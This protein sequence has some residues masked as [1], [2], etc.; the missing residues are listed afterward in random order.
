MSHLRKLKLISMVQVDSFKVLCSTMTALERL[1]L[2]SWLNMQLNNEGF[3]SITKLNN[4]TSLYIYGLDSLTDEG[5]GCVSRLT[6]LR[7]LEFSGEGVTTD[8]LSELQPLTN[9]K[10][11]C[12]NSSVVKQ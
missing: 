5:F 1:Y 4:L 8:V 11:L 9:L 7:K 2:W 10:F 6:R 3:Q 12:L